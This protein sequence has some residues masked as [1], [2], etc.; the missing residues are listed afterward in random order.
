MRKYYYLLG[1]ALIACGALLAV[2][3]ADRA[4]GPLRM[5]WEH[6]VMDGHRTGVTVASADNVREAMGESDGVR[7][8]APNGTVFEGGSTPAVAKLLID[9]QPRFTHLKQVLAYA[10]EALERRKPESP[11]YDWLA[12]QLLADVARLTGHRCDVSIAN[13]GGVRA[14][15]PAGNVLADD[16]VS[17]FPFR[18]Y[19][20]YVALSGSDLLRIFEQLAAH[21][22]IIG[23]ARMVVKDGKIKHLEVGGRPIDRNKTY[24]LATIDFLLDGGDGLRLARNARELIVTETRVVDAMLP[25][26][27]AY[28]DAGRPFTYSCDG[29]FII[30]K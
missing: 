3:I 25:A 24:G 16:L 27:K 12:D 10:P 19:L 20:C 23:G 26:V 28:G 6:F 17:M 22:Q 29:R 11:L 4:D 14:D 8:T 7:Y 30:E 2:R 9:V 1:F 5:E 18:N 21:P 13:F 15:I